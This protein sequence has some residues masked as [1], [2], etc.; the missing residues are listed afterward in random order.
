MRKASYFLAVHIDF[1]VAARS[2]L[3]DP[4]FCINIEEPCSGCS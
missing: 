4:N 2:I 3:I 1:S